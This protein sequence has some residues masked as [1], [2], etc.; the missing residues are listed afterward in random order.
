MGRPINPIGID[1]NR[2]AKLGRRLLH[3]WNAKKN[4][5]ALESQKAKKVVKPMSVIV[6][7]IL[8]TSAIFLIA[9]AVSYSLAAVFSKPVEKGHLDPVL[10]SRWHVFLLF[11][12]GILYL[13]IANKLR[14]LDQAEIIDTF[15]ICTVTLIVIWLFVQGNNKGKSHT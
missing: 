12:S 10:G 3:S 1:R 15:L 11:A 5:A 14:F 6:Y 2:N 4:Q 7:T 8:G 13:V 9:L